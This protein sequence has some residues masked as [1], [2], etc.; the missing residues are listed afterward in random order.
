VT[1]LGLLLVVAVVAALAVS[2]VAIPVLLVVWIVRT[3]GRGTRGLPHG[4]GGFL[5]R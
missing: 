5:G 2:P 4:P 3:L 1:V